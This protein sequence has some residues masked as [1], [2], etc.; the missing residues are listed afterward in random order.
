M[1]VY[2]LIF[3]FLIGLNFIIYGENNNDSIHNNI[4]EVD[5]ISK[6]AKPTSDMG[7]KI[8]LDL[9]QGL[10]VIIASIVAVCGISSWRRETKWKR[11]YE[12]AEEVLSNFYE[13]S[14]SFEVIRHPAGYVGEGKTRVKNKSETLEE[15]EILDQAYVVFERYEK[16]KEPFVKLMSL[17]Y[18]FMVLFGKEAVEP[19]N[20]IFKLRNTLFIA[21][22]RLGRRYWKDQGRRQ[23]EEKQFEKHLKEME[24]QEAIFWSDLSDEDE[25][26]KQVDLTIYKIENICQNIIEKR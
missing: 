17:K 19:F 3:T 14:E 26:K 13:V 24:K 12:L 23:F 9:I 18:R 11:K 6:P 25:F 1:K 20:E 16:E 15:S 8:Y 2:L 7:L 4:S 21:A 22:N 5:I 10:S